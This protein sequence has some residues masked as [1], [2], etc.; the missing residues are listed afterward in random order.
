MKEIRASG[1]EVIVLS[2][3]EIKGFAGNCLE[4]QTRYDELVLAI[5]HTATQALSPDNLAALQRHLRFIE[6]NVP[7]IE[8][9]GGGGVSVLKPCA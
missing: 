3:D 6:V 8:K 9:Y 4:L 7:T 5:S 2:L 1:R